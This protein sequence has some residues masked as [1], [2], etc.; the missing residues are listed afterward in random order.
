V[1][2]AFGVA[3][4]LALV[5]RLD[6]EA[7]DSA[8]HPASAPSDRLVPPPR[9]PIPVAVLVS[10]GATVI[11][12]AGPWEVFQDTMVPS[13]GQSHDEQMPFQLYTVADSTDPV[14]V[15]GGLRIVPDYTVDDAPAPR[16]IV[17]PAMRASERVLAWLRKTS[18]STDLTMSVCTGAFVLGLANHCA[19]PRTSRGSRPSR[20]WAWCVGRSCRRPGRGSC[21]PGI[22][23]ADRDTWRRT[24]AHSH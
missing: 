5:T 9:G 14:R 6:P 16:V 8:P 10:E 22:R 7:F 1:F 17:V 21:R 15:T 20:R 2:D 23:A 11:D 12:F 19:R 3:A 24:P 18:P 13:R 4:S